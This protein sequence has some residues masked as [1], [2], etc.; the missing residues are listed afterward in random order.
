MFATKREQSL[1]YCNSE[2]HNKLM[3]EKPVIEQT[4]LIKDNFKL[5]IFKNITDLFIIK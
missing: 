1:M 3:M 5:T 2:N 4:P